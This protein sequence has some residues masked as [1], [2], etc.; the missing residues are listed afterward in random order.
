MFVL[1]TKI[2]KW[3]TEEAE[4][5]FHYVCNVVLIGGSGGCKCWISHFHWIIPIKTNNAS[6][7]WLIP[8]YFSLLCCPLVYPATAYYVK[9]VCIFFLIISVR[10]SPNK[11]LLISF[12]KTGLQVC[13]QTGGGYAFP[14]AAGI[15]TRCIPVCGAGTGRYRYVRPVYY[16]LFSVF[17]TSDL[18]F[19]DQPLGQCEYVH[20]SSTFPLCGG[21]LSMPSGK[22][23][24][25]PVLG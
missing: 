3:S 13:T 7:T 24:R 23:Q 12:G 18:S 1:T 22:W 17:V 21:Q 8:V 9:R 20:R 16:S 6:S 5:L 14:E 19:S 11:Q 25:D 2:W 10:P 15:G 4:N